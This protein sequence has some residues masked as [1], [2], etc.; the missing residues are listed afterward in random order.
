MNTDLLL[1]NIGRHIQLDSEETDFFISILQGRKLKRKEFLLRPGEVCKTEN[2]ITK[3]CLRAYTIDENGFEHILMFGIEDWWIGDLHSL[4][5]QGPATYFVQALEDA[6]VIQ[7]TKE[8][9]DK[10]LVRVPKFERFYRI[11]LQKSLI[12]LHQR[13]SQNL[14]LSAE[15]RYINFVKKYPHLEDRLSQKQIAAYLGITPIF[16]S[17]LRKRLAITSNS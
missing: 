10:L 9:L 15:E 2:F 4:L 8:N 1:K 6:E 13:V 3:G 17:V 16:L 14:A 11:M 5:T 12:A 7:Y